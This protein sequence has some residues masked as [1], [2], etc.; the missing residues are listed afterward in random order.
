MK[1][2][3][4]LN[5]GQQFFTAHGP[6]FVT[7][8]GE[9]YQRPIAVIPERVLTDWPATTFAGLEAR[10]FEFFL[11]LKPEVVLLGTGTEHRFAHPAL[12]QALSAAGIGVECMNTAAACRTY[13]ILMSE[14]RKV[15]AAILF[16]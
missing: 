14:D 4:S 9:R 2:S 5:P 12:Y 3:L 16:E 10:H 13:N 15:V 7:V 6:D 8:S 11:A 1:L